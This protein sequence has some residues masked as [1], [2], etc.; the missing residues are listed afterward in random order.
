MP[1]RDDEERARVVVG[2]AGVVVYAKAVAVDATASI[3]AFSVCADLRAQPGRVAFVYV[4][5]VVAVGFQFLPGRAE[6]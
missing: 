2:F 1:I 4:L 6:T 5:A 3:G